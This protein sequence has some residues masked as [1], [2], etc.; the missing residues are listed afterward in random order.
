ME[1][2]TYELLWFFLA[3]AFLGWLAETALAAAKRGRLINRGFLNMPFSPVYGL[4]AVL[5]SI[6]LP[7]L[8]DDPFFLFLFGMVIATA[9]ELFTGVFLQKLTGERW[10]DYSGQRFQFEG[11]I[12]LKYAVLWGLS[13]LFCM[14]VGNPV[15]AALAGL[16]PRRV[17]RIV[18]LAVYILLAMDISAS[19]AAVFQLNGSVKEPGELSRFLRR[20]TDSLDNAVTRYVQRRIAR[21]YPSLEREHLREKA[22]GRPAEAEKAVFAGG[23]GF[24]KLACLFFIAAFLGDIIETVFCRLTMGVWMSRSSVVWG[25]FSVVWGLGAVLLTAVLYKY[26]DR[27]DRYIFLVG[28]VA[29]G[30]YEY[31]CSVFTELV[32]G[33]VFWDYS[34]IPFNLGGRVNLLYCF[35]WGIAAVVWLKGIYPVLSKWIERLPIRVGKAA[36]WLM[37]VFMV[38]NMTVSGLAL[39]RYTERNTSDAPSQS[40]LGELLDTHFPDERMERIYPKAVLVED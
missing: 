5:F 4:A 36:T 22:A 21:A 28:T 31:I 6:F 37:L 3:Y 10:W 25:P 1:Y 14:F 11:Y 8:R 13:A 7:E 12:S 26:K 27:N 2:T 38:A 15:L 30:A 39:A 29:G 20:L 16:I 9:L 32:F 34:H 33:A 24:Y 23:C 18:L 35:F 40:A 19:F 17:G